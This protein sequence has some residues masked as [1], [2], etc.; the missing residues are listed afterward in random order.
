[1]KLK[2]TYPGHFYIVDVFAEKKFA[3]NQLAVFTPGRTYSSEEMLLIAREMHFSETTFITSSDEKSGGYDVR[4]FTPEGELPFA[5]H[6][7]LGTAW[8]M[9]NHLLDNQND[10]I[11]LNLGVGQIPVRWETQSGK[12]I[13]FMTQKH[14]M[15]LDR[16]NRNM[17][18]TV[19]RLEAA[20]FD[21]RFPVQIVST[22]ISFCIVPIK[23]VSSVRECSPQMSEVAS[24]NARHKTEGILIFSPNAVEKGHDVHAR[25]FIGWQSIPEDPAT[26]SAN[27]CLAGYFS[28]HYFFGSDVVAVK[29]EQGYEI[30]RPSLLYLRAKRIDTAIEV[31]VGGNVIPIAEGN[32]L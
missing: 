9:K 31:Q 6:P 21:N 8:A 11:K 7:T 5:G 16:I 3:G 20:Q 17:L 14:P 12:S 26:G 22:G 19:L 24:F 18:S 25:V 27:G 23:D 13:P 4:I 15:F 32:F 30:H 28:H 1:M 2:S 10:E 29:V